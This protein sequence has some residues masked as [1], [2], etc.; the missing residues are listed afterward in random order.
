MKKLTCIF[1][2]IVLCASMTACVMMGTPGTQQPENEVDFNAPA[3]IVLDES[4]REDLRTEAFY[5][6]EGICIGYYRFTNGTNCGVEGLM[7][8]EF[9]DLNHTVRNTYEPTV[10]GATLGFVRQ[11]SENITQIY[12][13]D[14]KGNNTSSNSYLLYPYSVGRPYTYIENRK[15]VTVRCDLYGVDGN[16]VRTLTPENP[17][18]R[19]T[20]YE[21][22][23][24][25]FSVS[26]QYY[27]EL[28]NGSHACTV[29]DLTYD[30]EGDLLCEIVNTIEEDTERMMMELA[31]AEVRNGVGQTLRIYERSSP[32]F[33][34]RVSYN[35][36][37]RMLN[38]S[39]SKYIYEPTMGVMIPFT[40]YFDVFTNTV[41]YREEGIYEGNNLVSRKH[42]LYG[43]ELVTTKWDGGG[44]C[45]LEI[46]DAAGALKKTYEAPEGG[47]LG[48][49]W[50]TMAR[51]IRVTVYDGESNVIVDEL[52]PQ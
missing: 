37:D 15:G 31:R 3:Q 26:E 28:A 47:I 5:N 13:S 21:Y 50:D 35:P 51:A 2:I 34:L 14:Y 40:E 33:E 38:A 32:D 46:Y 1:L 49:S 16:V 11:G 44:Y 22:Q 25:H 45:K 20:V 18:N 29:R 9:L 39:E 4:E 36:N 42:V 23:V 17:E 19:L 24:N 10:A 43:G 12:E 6:E 27:V 8:L 30:M 41:L 48:F 7:R 52:Y